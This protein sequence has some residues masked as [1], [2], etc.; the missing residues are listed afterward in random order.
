M[1]HIVQ[2]YKQQYNLAINALSGLFW[3]FPNILVLWNDSLFV[4]ANYIIFWTAPK[5]ESRWVMGASLLST[6]TLTDALVDAR[7]HE[8]WK[9]PRYGQ[10]QWWGVGVGRPR[11]GRRLL[12]SCS[13]GTW[14]QSLVPWTHSPAVTF[15]NV[16]CSCPA[17]PRP[18][19]PSPGSRGEMIPGQW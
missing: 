14:R 11:A 12:S 6:M 9:T 1:E 13:G 15:P 5:L 4:L 19:S 16:G 2:F 18:G 3:I 10:W 8:M 7:C 17:P